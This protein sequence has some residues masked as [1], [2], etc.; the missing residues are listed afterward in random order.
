MQ[1]H[2]PAKTGDGVF[3]K[4]VENIIDS[5]LGFFEKFRRSFLTPAGCPQ[6]DEKE[7]AEKNYQVVKLAQGFN[8][9][10][11]EDKKTWTY[12]FNQQAMLTGMV[13]VDDGKMRQTIKTLFIQTPQGMAVSELSNEE[14]NQKMIINLKIKYQ[15]VEGYHLPAVFDYREHVYNQK[16]GTNDF[17]T[18]ITFD[19]FRV[20]V[21]L[22][23]R[24]EIHF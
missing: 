11:T 10:K 23:P 1:Y 5:G 6:F 2:Y 14:T 4:E 15:D 7:V 8:M 22:P 3:D 20:N 16:P 21:D 19:N 13:F 24:L 18:Q 12:S 17:E 9:I